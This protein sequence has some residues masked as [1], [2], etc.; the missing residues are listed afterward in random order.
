MTHCSGWLNLPLPASVVVEKLGDKVVAR[1]K[2]GM[3]AEDV[4]ASAVI[5][6]AINSLTPGRTWKEKVVLKGDFIVTK[7]AGKSYAIGLPSYTIL[8]ILGKIRLADN[9]SCDVIANIDQS[10]GNHH[11][12]II[13]GIIDGNKTNQTAGSGIKL[14]ASPTDW[15]GPYCYR[16]VIKNVHVYNC[17]AYGFRFEACNDLMITNCY[18]GVV[19]G[20]GSGYDGFYIDSCHEVFLVG[21]HSIANGRDG[22]RVASTLASGVWENQLANCGSENNSA[23]A[24]H[25][26]GGNIMACTLVGCTCDDCPSGGVYVE[27]GEEITISGNS[28]ARGTYG[29]RVAASRVNV[30]GNSIREVKQGVCVEASGVNVVGNRIHGKKEADEYGVYLASGVNNCL[31]AGNLITYISTDAGDQAGILLYGNNHYNTIIANKIFDVGRFGIRLAPGGVSSYN[32]IVNNHIDTCVTGIGIYGSHIYNHISKNM[33]RNPVYY[34]ISLS[35]GAD[36]NQVVDNVLYGGTTIYLSDTAGVNNVIKRNFGFITENSGAAIITAGN[37]YVN[38]AHGLNIIPDINRI[39]LTPKDNLGGRNWWVS[40]VGAT[41]FRIN[42]SS[43][44]TVDHAFGW[45]YE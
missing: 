39:K 4:D 26:L 18:S 43:A 37:T 12:E 20:P 3:I 23:W 35:A 36:Y 40:D 34:G 21:C 30:V 8:E 7:Q 28:L 24:Y 27:G 9:Q 25:F 15:S 44:D 10:G 22:Y 6:S 1:S 13:G 2:D 38:V 19:G 41:T 29:V 5:Q 45:S 31:V 17:K 14:K 16:N 11:I 33:I 42:I 32:N